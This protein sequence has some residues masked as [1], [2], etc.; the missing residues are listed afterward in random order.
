MAEN[1][2]PN[3]NAGGG[4][5]GRGSATGGPPLVQHLST[6]GLTGKLNVYSCFVNKCMYVYVKSVLP[7]IL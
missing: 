7:L 2:D 6:T 1:D 3:A 5:S 4:G